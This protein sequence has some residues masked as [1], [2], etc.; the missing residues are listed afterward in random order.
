MDE[1]NGIVYFGAGCFWH[2]EEAFRCHKGVTDTTV[3]YMGGNKADP[4]YEDVCSGQSGHTEIVKITF[5]REQLTY[6]QLLAR[7]FETH[8]PTSLNKQGPDIGFQYRSV[9]FYT[10]NEQKTQA[11]EFIKELKTSKKYHAPIVTSVEPAGT[12]WPAEEY[13]QN[14]L[15]KHKMFTC[16]V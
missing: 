3:G 14:Y 15:A 8:D 7:F 2:T 1:L 12:F 10:D 9:I 11:E 6:K 16:V 4:T 5:N 13:H